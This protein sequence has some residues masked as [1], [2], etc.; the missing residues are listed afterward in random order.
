MTTPTETMLTV[1]EAAQLLMVTPQWVRDLGA[2]GYIPKAEGGKVPMVAAVQG[3]IK[4]LKDEERRTSKTAAQS[5][6]Q[7]ARA[8]EIELRIA[9]ESGKL[10]DLEDA[11]TTFATILGIY[12]SELAGVAAA[13]TRDLVL[14]ETIDRALNDAVARARDR[15]RQHIEA[16]RTGRDIGL[17]DP[18]PIPG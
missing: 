5:A 12:R 11:E 10:I 13:S 7:Q 8:R 4:W 2:K 16:L 6:V 3:Y 1:A 9:R 18:A 14:R 17:D 15:F